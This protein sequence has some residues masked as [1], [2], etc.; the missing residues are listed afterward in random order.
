LK[1]LILFSILF[2]FALIVKGQTD[3]R[4]V[5]A[6]WAAS[7]ITVDGVLDEEA[8]ATTEATG[9]FYQNFP[10]D[11]SYAVTQT[12]V[13]I[14]FD[15]NFVY[16]GAECFDDRPQQRYVITSLR[17]DFS[18]TSDFFQIVIDPFR[19]KLN[20]FVFGVNP[21]GV[22]Q[23]GMI[24]F[25]VDIDWGWDNKWHSDVRR[26]EDRWVVEMAIPLKTLRFKNGSEHWGVNFL[27]SELK[28]N[29][30]S[31]W[32]KVGRVYTLQGLAF[33]GSLNFDRPIQKNG[34]NV[35]LIPY[36][37]GSTN[38]D[39]QNEDLS[40]H[41]FNTGLDAKVAVTSSLNL[42]LTVNPDFS[43][44]EVDRQVTNLSRFEIFFPERRQ[45]F[46][47]NSDIFAR[48]G[49]SSIR[50]FF[51]RRIGAGEDPYTGQFKQNPIL[52]GARL[53]GRI[54]DDW[55]IGLLNMQTTRQR[56]I[57]LES[58]NY[59]V[60]AI[61]KSIFRRSSIA[62]ILVNKQQTSDSLHDFTLASE[63]HDRI[64]G[65]DYNLGSAD[66]KWEGKFFLHKAMTP[67]NLPDAYTH[68]SYLQ[69][70]GKY[71]YFEHNHEFVGEGYN[72]ETGYV[73]RQNYWRLEPNAGFWFYPKNDRLINQHGPSG[74]G[75]AFWRKSDGKLLDADMDY[76]WILNFQSTASLRIFYRYD[77]TYLFS[78]F[79][80]T[81]TAGL[82]LPEGSTYIYHSLRLRFQSNTRRLFN[83]YKSV[84]IG[85][86]FNGQIYSLTGIL[87]YRIQPYGNLA[88]DYS[89][90]SIR[91]PNPYSDADLLLIGPSIDWAFSKEVFAKIVVQY[92]NQI[93]NVNTN[94][95]LQWRFKP[96]SDFYLVYTDNYTETG[97][98][99][100]RG[101]VF[102][103][104]YWLSL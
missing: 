47:E 50:P 94:I 9:N 17:R 56:S 51:S 7:P 93:N 71:F 104:T 84:R 91:L 30:L 26:Y 11:T 22:Q 64:V 85:Q 63:S 76:G 90:N 36:A 98:V 27:R 19:D 5:N 77:Y 42:D 37:S 99:K 60:A 82:E 66:G 43:Q 57:D 15:Q 70:N 95:R 102:K 86:Y 12:L 72:A 79:D 1:Y 28:N 38:N 20:G 101:L 35:S 6:R 103:L 46:I 32:S 75:D 88:L 59:T 33:E 4:T 16:V 65:V 80:P 89:I 29:E 2:Q 58:A 52:Y 96:V 55:R 87:N 39:F 100:S 41:S 68:A 24:S 13:R 40:E 44:V 34:N 10:N 3:Q 48:F 81:N 23:E 8:W 61:Q 92:N 67:Q 45:F 14:T 18:T 53:S 49:F 73:P 69:F 74:G 21:L 54:N 62:A 78:P 25:G 97:K 83:Y 31:A